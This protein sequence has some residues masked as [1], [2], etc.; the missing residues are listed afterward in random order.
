MD[1]FFAAL[2]SN[3][4]VRIWGF[5]GSMATNAD[6]GAR[7]WTGLDRVVRAAE[8]AGQ[9]LIVSLA[10]Q[11]GNCDD[12]H[13]KDRA[14]YEG[15]YR[16]LYGG[17]GRTVATVSYWDWIHE[18]VSRYRS[19][20]AIAG[21]ELVNEP[22]A[23][24]CAA[25]SMSDCYAHLLCPDESAAA[26][27]LRQFVDT[28]GGEIKRI[29]PNHL[30]ESGAMGGGQCGWTANDYAFVHASPG[31]DVASYH[32]YTADQVLGQELPER[33]AQANTLGKPIIV[34]ELGVRAGDGISDC[35]SLT[36]RR[37][38]IQAKANA[39][40]SGGAAAVL[41]WDV[42]PNPSITTCT[43]DVG[44]GDPLLALLG[45]IPARPAP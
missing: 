21:W 17:D 32:D 5:Q 28:V 4:T 3:S 30:V 18:I 33:L 15:G 26:L 41:V 36:Q 22:E 31:V 39:M 19:S 10:N 38:L 24:E 23:S 27:A 40:M 6:T 13:W 44:S 34:G 14:W 2:P 43:F 1:A 8:R 45:A 11:S 9:H 20:T 25:G 29:D 37:D 7:D 35:P 16:G 12:G 42:V